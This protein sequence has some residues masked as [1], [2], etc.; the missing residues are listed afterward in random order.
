M[1]ADALSQVKE[2]EDCAAGV[3]ADATTPISGTRASAAKT[4]RMA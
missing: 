4:V 1:T 2:G 3:S